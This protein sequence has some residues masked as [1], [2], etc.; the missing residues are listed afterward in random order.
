MIDEFQEEAKRIV[1]D[2]RERGSS[3]CDQAAA[4]IEYT[5]MQ[6]LSAV[7]ERDLEN[8]DLEKEFGYSPAL[9]KACWDSFDYAMMLRSGTVVYFREARPVS[10][11]WVTLKEIHAVMPSS[12]FRPDVYPKP[13][14]CRGDETVFPRGLDVRVDDIVWI[15]DAPH[16]S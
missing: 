9:A 12:K 8:Q 6:A 1:Q 11:A 7:K 3:I 14:F 4:E 2:A 13:M 16:G 5:I 15:A 10:A